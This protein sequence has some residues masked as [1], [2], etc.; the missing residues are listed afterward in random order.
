MDSKKKSQSPCGEVL[1]LQTY[2]KKPS[3]PCQLLFVIMHI[4]ALL[5]ALYER[6]RFI[7][8]DNISTASKTN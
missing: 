6:G 7:K 8:M 1:A 2:D 3:H 5:Q 4:S